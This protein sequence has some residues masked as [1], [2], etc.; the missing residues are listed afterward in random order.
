MHLRVK[1]KRLAAACLCLAMLRVLVA[2]EPEE[3]FRDPSAGTS[4]KATE[5]SRSS[6]D[7]KREIP[8]NVSGKGASQ[9]PDLKLP[10]PGAP[11]PLD[12][13]P[14]GD[15]KKADEKAAAPAP[16]VGLNP[17][18]RENI[19]ALEF[20]E[21]EYLYVNP[22]SVEGYAGWKRNKVPKSALINQDLLPIPDRWRQGMPQDSRRVIGNLWNPY[23]QNMLKGDYPVIG[24]SIFLTTLFVSDTLVEGHSVP[25]PANVSTQRPNSERFFGHGDQLVVVQNFIIS[26]ELFK[27]ETD[28][29]PREWE[30]RVTP[31]FN[32]NYVRTE[33]NFVINLDPRRG[34]D[35]LDH[36]CALQELFGEYHFRDISKNYDFVSS[37]TGIQFYNND[38]RGFLFAD[39]NLGFRAFGILESNRLQYNLAYF[40]MLDKDTNSGLNTVFEFKDEHVVMGNIVRQDTLIKG[41]NMIG[42][43]GFS[44]EESSNQY[45]QNGLIVRPAPIGD[46]NP[47]SIRTGYVGFGGD[48]HIG[49]L[50]ISHQFYQAFGTDNHNPLSGKRQD[51]NAQMFA[52]ELSIDVDWMRF[53]TSCFYS[54]GDKDVYDNT[55]TGFDAIFD[56]PNF[57]GGQFSYWVRQGFG[58]GNS[59][60]SL[61]SRFSLI[62]NLATSKEQGQSNFVNPGVHLFNVGYDAELTPRLKAILNV[63]YLRFDET[64]PLNV[65]LQR[66]KLSR[67]IGVDY[68]M[69]MIYRPLLSQNIVFTGAIAGLTPLQ[70]FKDIYGSKTLYSAFLGITLKY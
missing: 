38:F 1:G 22:P 26:L 40:E 43:F 48:G 67:E 12:P 64:E 21:M 66:E 42:N 45:N 44:A 49:R 36:Q 6:L 13:A 58:A 29:K 16:S 39:N 47:H 30:I 35:R 32:L 55:A 61:K 9:L 34:R 5:A 54:S 56:N 51:I 69:G 65:L 15:E 17:T 18:A 37:R 31:V 28:F 3:L 7:A 52:L 19:N 70:G 20:E 11:V 50:N 63:N 53:R 33:E 10:D 62:P 23:R 57:A 27:G 8:I 41:Y 24:Q 14:V 60:T 46:L 2:A 59:A 25:T 68:S 4:A